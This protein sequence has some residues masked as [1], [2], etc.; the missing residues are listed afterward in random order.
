MRTGINWTGLLLLVLAAWTLIGLIGV[1]V[2]YRKGERPKALR[3]L[4]TIVGIWLLYFAVLLGISLTAHPRPIARGQEQCFGDR[5]LTV[6]RADPMP[7][8]VPIGDERLLRVSLRI[9]NHSREKRLGDTSLEAF[10]V[11]SRGRRW[12]SVPGLGGVP[13]STTVAPSGSI[14]SEPVFRLPSS[15]TQLRL[16]FTHGRGLPNALLLGD[17]DSLLHP[18]VFVPLE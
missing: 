9:S 2:T 13:I 15:A 18:Q 17:R 4:A 3:H 5:C 16:V 1:S 8:Y 11:D 7:G 10:L 14:I 6:L 12:D